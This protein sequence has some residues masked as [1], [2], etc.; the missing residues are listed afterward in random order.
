MSDCYFY[1]ISSHSCWRTRM[2]HK[3]VDACLCY[4]VI[5]KNV[6]SSAILTTSAFS[7]PLFHH[8]NLFLERVLASYILDL[9]KIKWALRIFWQKSNLNFQQKK[10]S[11]F[12]F[13]ISNFRG[14][15]IFSA[16]FAFHVLVS[17]RYLRNSALISFN[18]ETLN[19]NANLLL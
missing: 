18:T 14:F 16:S 8:L 11:Y 4:P 17:C 1:I 3:Q 7:Q 2:K 9:A 15:Y 12:S 5:S 10:I 6:V 13:Q 19:S